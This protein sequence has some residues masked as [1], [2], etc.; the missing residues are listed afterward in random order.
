MVTFISWKPLVFC[1]FK[2]LRQP[3]NPRSFIWQKCTINHDPRFA[4]RPMQSFV[5]VIFRYISDLKSKPNFLCKC[6]RLFLGGRTAVYSDGLPST[7]YE[8]EVLDSF[9]S[10]YTL[11]QSQKTP[12]YTPTH[13]NTSTGAVANKYKLFNKRHLLEYGMCLQLGSPNGTDCFDFINLSG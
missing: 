6:F 9:L 1:I 13:T 8:T 12:V 7:N 10:T 2:R 3:C 4:S 5:R 11:R